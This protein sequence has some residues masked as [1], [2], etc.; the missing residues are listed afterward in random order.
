M[1]QFYP[2]SASLQT[3]WEP[4]GGKHFPK[5]RTPRLPVAV[6]LLW[7]REVIWLQY[8]FSSV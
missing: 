7:E 4:A 3:R 8:Q 5:Q 1:K 2:I 6:L